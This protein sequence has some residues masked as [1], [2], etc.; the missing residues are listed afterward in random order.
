MACIETNPNLL[1]SISCIG[2]LASDKTKAIFIYSVE[3]TVK[4]TKEEAY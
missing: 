1:P 2:L 4:R 3:I